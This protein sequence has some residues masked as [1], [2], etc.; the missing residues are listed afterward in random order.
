MPASP[1]APE[2]T[3][4]RRKVM[5]TPTPWPVFCILRQPCLYGVLVNVIYLLTKLIVVAHPVMKHTTL[6]PPLLPL[7]PFRETRF[8]I[9]GPVLDR[10]TFT[11]STGTTQ[12]VEV[13]R[14]QDI[15]PD[16]PHRGIVQPDIVQ[17][18]VDQFLCHPGG[19]RLGADGAEQD[20]RHIR[21]KDDA[22]RRRPPPDSVSA[23]FVQTCHG[24]SM[25]QV[26]ARPRKREWACDGKKWEGIM[27]NKA[28]VGLR[29]P[30]SAASARYLRT[31]RSASLPSIL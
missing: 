28:R 2:R 5:H 20:Q 24:D 9:L 8:P 15:V 7:D 29:R 16:Q 13:I 22:L 11:D 1:H 12:K 31:R 30:M 17:C 26:S 18:V 10:H 6:P 4:V 25:E 27:G 21:R 23:V 19:L 3:V 14:H